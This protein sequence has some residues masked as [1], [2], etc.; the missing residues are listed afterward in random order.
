MTAPAETPAWARHRRFAEVVDPLLGLVDAAGEPVPDEMQGSRR[1][2]AWDRRRQQTLLAI[3]GHAR[4][5]LAG[6]VG[7]GEPSPMWLDRFLASAA[8]AHDP[9][10][11]AVYGRMLATETLRPGTVSL[12]ALELLRMMDAADLARFGRF[13][14]FAIGNFVIRLKE[15]FYEKYGI[16]AEDLLQFEEYRLLRP[17]GSNIKQFP[18]QIEDRFQ[19]HLLLADRVLRVSAAEPDRK[20]VLPCHRLTAA[21]A[22]IAEAMALPVVNDY[23]TQIVDLIEK[24]GYTVAHARIVE[25]GDR[26]TVARHSRFS[27]IVSFERLRSARR[28]R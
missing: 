7:A 24:R 15:G 20:L 22:D 5:A 4:Q 25:R 28:R 2:E 23:I 3:A 13:A 9:A 19:T 27:D 1:Q 18:S 11:Q 14:Q 21:G 16:E 17:G 12:A 6:R 8:D 26:N 10:L